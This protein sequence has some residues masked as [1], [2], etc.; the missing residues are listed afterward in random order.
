MKIKNQKINKSL[1]GKK[2][3]KEFKDEWKPGNKF[4]LPTHMAKKGREKAKA[5]MPILL[6]ME[7]II[8]KKGLYICK[9][10]DNG[11]ISEIYLNI[12]L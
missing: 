8:V 2:F 10:G 12:I 1:I 7:N 4:I 6:D 9:W 11:D 3:I 5:I